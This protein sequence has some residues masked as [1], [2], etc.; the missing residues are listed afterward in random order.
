MPTDAYLELSKQPIRFE[1][2]NQFTNVFYDDSRKQV[3]NS[4][5]VLFKTYTAAHSGRFW[6]LR[7][8]PK[9]DCKYI[10]A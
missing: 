3:R 5:F 1:A 7:P 10:W 2:V 9:E 4:D 8:C 6:S